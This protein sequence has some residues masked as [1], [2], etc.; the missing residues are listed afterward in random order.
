[1]RPHSRAASTTSRCRGSPTPATRSLTR[2]E[3]KELNAEYAAGSS[4]ADSD[5]SP[6]YAELSDLPDAL[7]AVGSLDPLLEDSMLMA[8]RWRA[9]GSCARLIVVPDGPHGVDAADEVHAFLRSRFG[10]E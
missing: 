7:F 4:L 10:S 9:A 5:L 2:Q 6:A 8:E 3:L 1:V